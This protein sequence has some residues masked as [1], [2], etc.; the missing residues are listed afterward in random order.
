MEIWTRARI[1]LIPSSM[2]LTDTRV[3]VQKYS[4]LPDLTFRLQ[5]DFTHQTLASQF[6][7]AIPA[8]LWSP[9]TSTVLPDGTTILPDGRII[10]PSGKV[11]GHAAPGVDVLW[12]DTLINPSNQYTAQASVEKILNRGFFGLTGSISRREYEKSTAT[13]YTVAT[14]SGQASTWL[15]PVFYAYTHGS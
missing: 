8:G 1:R 12:T 4:P 13:D 15:G 11:V 14:M 6:V 9:G 7:N 10:D 2:S 3:F 5:G